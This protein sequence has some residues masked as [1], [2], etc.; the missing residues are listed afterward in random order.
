VKVFLAGATGAIGRRLVPLLLQAGHAVTG[1]SRKPEGL[2][3]LEE[4][5]VRPVRVDAFDVDAVAVAVREAHPDAIINQLTDLP[6][7]HDAPNF[8]EALKA[9][10]ELRR[11][12]TV[13]LV[14][15]AVAAGTPR[16]IT[17]TLA[18]VYDKGREPHGEDDPL[19]PG[20]D[21]AIAA[22]RSVLDARGIAGTVLRYGLLY[23]PGTWYAA[24]TGKPPVHVDAAAHAAHLALD[25][26]PG[27]YNIA[28]DTGFVSIDRARRLLKWDPAFR[29]P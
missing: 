26:P 25:A 18:F 17:A 19:D 10:A 27:I 11:V 13:N 28:D 23:G 2:A 7:T 14:R 9:N 24:P 21:A 6:P 3:H 1:T 20:A 15:A 8:D 12:G 22:E 16:L 4:A 29:L 5:G